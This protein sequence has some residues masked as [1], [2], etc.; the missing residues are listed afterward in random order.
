MEK[1]DHADDQ[2]RPTEPEYYLPAVVTTSSDAS[3]IDRIWAKIFNHR[4]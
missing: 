2:D 4:V 3:W 1:K